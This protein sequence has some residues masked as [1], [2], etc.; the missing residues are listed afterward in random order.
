MAERRCKAT[1]KDGQPCKA[2]PLRDGDFCLAH[3]DEET[4]E[5]TGFVAA[6]GKG[7]RPKNP[8]V[9]DVLR[10][11]LEER[12]DDVIGP[13]FDA[14]EADRGIAVGNGP[15][16]RVEYMTDHATR[17]AAVRELLDRVYGKPRS[18]TEITGPE[19]SAIEIVTVEADQDHAAEVA[20]ILAQTRAVASN[21]DG[22]SN[23]HH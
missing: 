10:E 23:G 15:S 20:R 18:T 8:R 11:R 9:I 1:T 17:I 14:L 5:S 12:I 4:R 7:G 2:A 19:G 3:A 6:N 21:G 16:A 22:S 13:L